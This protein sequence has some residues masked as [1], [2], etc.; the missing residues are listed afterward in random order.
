MQRIV[1]VGEEVLQGKNLRKSSGMISYFGKEGVIFK[2][3][4]PA[5]Q[6][7]GFVTR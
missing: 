4:F 2:E 7:R 5:E 3:F 6:K 1:E